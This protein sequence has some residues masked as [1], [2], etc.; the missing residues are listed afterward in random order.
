[1]RSLQCWAAQLKMVMRVVE[2]SMNNT[3]L[4]A[5]VR[6]PVDGILKF[7]DVFDIQW[8][9]Y[10]GSEAALYTYY[11]YIHTMICASGTG[12]ISSISE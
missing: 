12:G 6:K 4:G 9:N 8:W 5:P 2:P 10:Y 3:Y 1:M 11:S 7:S